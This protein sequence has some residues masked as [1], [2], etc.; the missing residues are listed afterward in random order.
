MIGSLL[1]G[2][3]GGLIAGL[4]GLGGGAV[5]VPGMVVLMHISQHQA[6]GTSLLAIVPVAAVGAYSHARH[7]DLRLGDGLLLGVLALGGVAAG[8]ALAN[9]LSGRVLR[10]AFACLLLTIAYR[11]VRGALSGRVGH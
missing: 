2:L 9:V 11:L 6:E 4:M 1:I 10:V 3:I 5:Y 8:V 7:G